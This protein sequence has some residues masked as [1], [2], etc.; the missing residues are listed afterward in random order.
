MVH[1]VLDGR[2][3]DV[4]MKTD[5]VFGLSMPTDCPDVPKKVLDPRNTWADKQDYDAT[6]KKLAA[7][8][9]QKYAEYAAETVA[10]EKS[11]SP[12]VV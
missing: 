8:F 5:P 6:A 3:A 4:P 12:L 9:A 11:A 7:K 1:A 10:D 2:L